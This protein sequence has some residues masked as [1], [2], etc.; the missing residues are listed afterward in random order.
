MAAVTL[1]SYVG[2]WSRLGQTT[3]LLL[4][5]KT[6][7]FIAAV[8]VAMPVVLRGDGGITSSYV[9]ELQDALAITS[10]GGQVANNIFAR[11]VY[12]RLENYSALSLLSPFITSSALLT[13]TLETLAVKYLGTR[14]TSFYALAAQL[15]S[16]LLR[17]LPLL[18]QLAVEQD[19]SLEDIVSGLLEMHDAT[20][21]SSSSVSM[22]EVRSSGEATVAVSSGTLRSEAVRAALTST[23]FLETVE[24]AQGLSGVDRLDTI[25]SS[26]CVI[27][28]RFVVEG[29]PWLRQM[30]PIFGDLSN[31]LD[32]RLPYFSRVVALDLVTGEVPTSVA[33][34]RWDSGACKLFL[35]GKW[36]K[37]DWVNV[38]TGFHDFE[39][40]AAV[41]EYYPVMPEELYLVQEN[42]IGMKQFAGRLFSAL[43]YP[44]T[45]LEGSSFNDLMDKQMEVA[46]YIAKQP[47]QLRG[48]WDAWLTQQFKAALA[49]AGQYFITVL[50]SSTPA[51]VGLEAWLPAGADYFTVVDGRMT[52]ARPVADVRCAFGDM[53]ITTPILVPGATP[54]AG[55]S[56]AGSSASHHG[57]LNAAPGGGGGGGGVADP[58]AGSKRK[59]PVVTA[60]VADTPGAK[61]SFAKPLDGGKRLFLAARVYD[62]E[63]ICL[64]YNLKITDH[65]WPVLLSSS[66]GLRLSLSA[67]ITPSTAGSTASCTNVLPTSIVSPRPR[68]RSPNQRPGLRFATQDGARTNAANLERAAGG[69]RGRSGWLFSSPHQDRAPCST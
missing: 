15:D 53:F 12:E 23:N 38:P 49:R 14:R 34:W 10:D 7:P 3:P 33:G 63:A 26:N 67:P 20:N 48:D 66:R 54:P 19:A 31:D 1:V 13:S 52:A 9:Q 43:G 69:T 56:V 29:T 55:Y 5:R 68:R 60:A 37:I 51:T 61:S 22:G 45:C 57:V 44:A 30:H 2:Q 64:K 16:L 58:K 8:T 50:R 17:R 11:R 35:E 24:A 41:S 21:V 65:C 6:P 18:R 59:Q 28:T 36:D 46:R 42:L 25:L 62:I 47:P 4:A 27:L 40:V 32:E 39:R